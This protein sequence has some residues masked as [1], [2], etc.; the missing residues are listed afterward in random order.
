MTFVVDV[1]N[2]KIK[3]ARFASGRRLRGQ[4]SA[5][6]VDAEDAALE[7]L[8]AAV[9]ARTGRVWVA[10]VAAPELTNRIGAVLRH[11]TGVDPVFVATTREQAG[12]RCAYD[13][14]SRLGVDRWMAM[15]A[16]Y[17]RVRGPICV[18]AAGTAVTF[19]AVDADG[20]HRGGLIF[21]GPRLAADALRRGTGR[22]G[23]TEVVSAPP[24][25]LA[26]LG[27]STDAAVG[28]GAWLS[29]SAA[30]ERAIAVVAA[31]DGATPA[32]VL[33]GGDATTLRRWLACEGEVVADLVLEGLA[34][35]AG[36]AD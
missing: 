31:A 28:H 13:D 16:A 24:E 25:G 22:I 14:P 29:L 27:R 11:K 23:P 7:A 19:D 35:V 34:L 3:W 2:A 15:I 9:P 10:S 5:L 12:V 30:L 4:G 26:L 18:I 8:A 32:V 20:R 21:A 17:A 1:G 33:T 36:A 6:H